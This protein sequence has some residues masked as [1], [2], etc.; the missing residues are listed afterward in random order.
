MGERQCQNQHMTAGKWI[1][2]IVQRVS[3]PKSY[4]DNPVK[5]QIT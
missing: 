4:F 1:D 3:L 5:T 2:M